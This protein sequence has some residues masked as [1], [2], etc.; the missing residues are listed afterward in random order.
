MP[1]SKSP[2]PALKLITEVAEATANELGFTLVDAHFGLQGRKTILE[3]TIYKPG[4]RIGLSDCELVSRE[5]E[6]RLESMKE[7]PSLLHGSYVLDVAS[8]G[9]ER[10]LKTEREFR[11]FQGNT[12][13]IKA[14]SDVGQGGFGQHFLAKLGAYEAE[15]NGKDAKVTLH[16]L[17]ELP[18]APQAKQ[19]KGK[20]KAKIAIEAV[21]ELTTAV[22]NLSLIKLYADLSKA[23]IEHRDDEVVDLNTTK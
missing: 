7:L 10:V 20:G 3:I 22:K 11:I 4:G 12:V 17:R 15:A 5:L 14:K 9:L 2:D 16:H 18:A 23:A 21:N 13:E 1:N 19:P 8:P 6:T